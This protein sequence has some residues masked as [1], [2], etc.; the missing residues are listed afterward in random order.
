M[1]RKVINPL[2]YLTSGLTISTSPSASRR[3]R[4]FQAV[5]EVSQRGHLE[6]IQ[7]TATGRLLRQQEASSSTNSSSDTTTSGEKRGRE[8]TG[9][10]RYCRTRPREGCERTKRVA[11]S[12]RRPGAFCRS[13]LVPECKFIPWA[14]MAS[15]ACRCKTDRVQSIIRLISTNP[16]LP[17]APKFDNGWTRSSIRM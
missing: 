11:G 6:E 17:F 10:V 14:E 15:D 9:G 13:V 4:C 2:Q 3:Q 1:A 8:A 12:V 16:M 5:L 7:G